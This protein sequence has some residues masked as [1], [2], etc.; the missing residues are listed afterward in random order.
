M[1]TILLLCFSNLFMTAAWYGHLKHPGAPLWKVVL[2]SWAIAFVE[3]CFAVP[4]NRLGY[5]SGFSAGQLKVIQEVVTLVTFAGFAALYLGEALKW[6][7]L[8]AFVCLIAAVG[9]MFSDRF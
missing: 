6:N 9:F 3:Y 5:A 7:H 4:A 8:A 1:T 2:V